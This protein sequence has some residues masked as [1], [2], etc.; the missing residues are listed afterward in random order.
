MIFKTIEPAPIYLYF[1]LNLN[2][3]RLG[4]LE[5]QPGESRPTAWSW[6][7]SQGVRGD[8]VHFVKTYFYSIWWVMAYRVKV[9]GNHNNGYLFGLIIIPIFIAMVIICSAASFIQGS[10]YHVGL[11]GFY[12]FFIFF[13]F[14]WGQEVRCHI[15]H[16]GS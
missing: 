9:V 13:S 10:N 11:W 6:A 8:W 4:W 1:Y 12:F 2:K 5:Q 14:S 7:P 15:W 3:V 16:V